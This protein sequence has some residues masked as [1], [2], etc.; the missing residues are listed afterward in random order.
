MES[1]VKLRLKP[2]GVWTTPLQADSLLGSL[3]VTWVRWHGVD[4]LKRDFLEPWLAGE[5]RFVISDAFPANALPAPASL[6]LPIWDW[7]A[8]RRKAVKQ[9][10]WLSPSAFSAMQRG[11]R[12]DLDESA[13]YIDKGVSIEKGVRMRNEVD[14]SSDSAGGEG[15]NLFTAPYQ[16]LSNHESHLTI[17]ARADTGGMDILVRSLELLGMTGFGARATAGHGGFDLDGDP[18]ACP[19]LDDVPSADAFVSLSTYQPAPS[20]P[21]DG[22]WRSFVKYGK[23]APEF[24]GANIIFKRPQI[25]LRAGACFRTGQAPNPYYG[26]VIPSERLLSDG[27]R[28]R[29]ADRDIHPVQGAF[30][31]ALPMVWKEEV[32]K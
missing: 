19:D 8:N 18:E 16:D 21:V 3:A 12:P 5:P 17:Y 11:E 23:M 15:G 13:S 29:L 27:N 10:E 22:Y 4:A 25:M 7:P 9:I 26:G 30:A 24:H 31:L 20:D 28:Q 32:S 2:T 6:P 1:L 14:R